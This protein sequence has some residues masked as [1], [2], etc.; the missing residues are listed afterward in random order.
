MIFQVQVTEQDIADTLRESRRLL[1]IYLAV[2]PKSSRVFDDVLQ[3]IRNISFF[4][5]DEDE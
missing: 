1:R 4:L 3:T 5:G 2:T